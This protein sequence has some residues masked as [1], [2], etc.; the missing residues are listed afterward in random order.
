[1]TRKECLDSAAKAVLSNRNATYG[2]PEDCFGRIA[3][4]WSAYLDMPV[5]TVDVPALM[6]LLK[7]ARVKAN[8]RHGD[9]WADLAGYAACGAECAGK[10]CGCEPIEYLA[11]L[12]GQVQTAPAKD[13]R[14]DTRPLADHYHGIPCPTM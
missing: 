5:S 7:L 1:M 8:P 12:N 6:A 2:G 4:L 14:Q 3:A 10:M 11:Y 9:S 13:R